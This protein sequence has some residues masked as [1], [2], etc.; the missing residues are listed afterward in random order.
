MRR[1]IAFPTSNF[2]ARELGYGLAGKW[3]RDDPGKPYLGGWAECAAAVRDHFAPQ[4]SYER[5]LDELLGEVQ[6]A[7]FDAVE[8]WSGHP[9]PQWATDRQV[10]IARELLRV[11]GTQAVGFHGYLADSLESASRACE[12]TARPGATPLTG[13]GGP[14]LDTNRA[15][16]VAVLRDYDVR[17]AIENHPEHATPPDLLAKV[18]DGAGGRIG[19]TWTQAG[20]APS[21]MTRSK[22]SMNWP[23]AC[24]TFSSKTLLRWAATTRADWAQAAVLDACTAAGIAFMPWPPI[25]QLA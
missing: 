13:G 5:R 10:T 17:L 23:P 7:G 6:G 12:I 14:F 2:I 19:S 11:R 9:N 1:P 3:R 16:T 20:G 21:A 18:G 8:I 25:G 15:T 22:R 24:S 4:D